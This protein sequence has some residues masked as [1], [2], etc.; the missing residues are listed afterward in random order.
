MEPDPI[1]PDALQHALIDAVELFRELKIGYALV[2]GLAAM[3]YGRARYTEDVDFV[4]QPDHEATLADHPDAMKR[5]RFDPSC[6]YTL[7]HDSGIQIDLWKDEHAAGIVERR[8]RRKVGDRFVHVAEPHDLIAMKLR[9]DRPQDDYD[10]SEILRDQAIDHARIKAGV[11]ASQFR[12]F[13]AIC[14]RIGLD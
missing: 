3:V 5:H 10:I 4:A 12:R 1:D 7:Y 8:V 14:R 2:G 13:E 9:A 6:I 11:T